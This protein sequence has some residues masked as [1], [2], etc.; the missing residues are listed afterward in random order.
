MKKASS[1]CSGSGSAKG[2]AAKERD[3][4]RA[5]TQ[6][7]R[8]LIVLGRFIVHL[9]RLE[10][11]G[12]DDKLGEVVERRDVSH[13]EVNRVAREQRVKTALLLVELLSDSV[14]ILAPKLRYI[15][16]SSRLVKTLSRRACRAGAGSGSIPAFRSAFRRAFSSGEKSDGLFEG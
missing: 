15:L 9:R 14:S 2:L 11:L 10:L 3:R 6:L 12:V 5:L 7:Q 16:T 4:A 8:L 13:R 1:G